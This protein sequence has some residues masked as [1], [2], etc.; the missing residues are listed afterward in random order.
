MWYGLQIQ[1][2][3]NPRC[4][5]DGLCFIERGP[6]RSTYCLGDGRF[7]H[8]IIPLSKRPLH[9]LLGRDLEDESIATGEARIACFRQY[10]LLCIFGTDSERT[11]AVAGFEVATVSGIDCPEEIRPITGSANYD[12]DQIFFCQKRHS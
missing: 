10:D 6:G 7:L 12:S 1:P 5:R 2:K 4:H 9:Q 8:E 11:L 3:P